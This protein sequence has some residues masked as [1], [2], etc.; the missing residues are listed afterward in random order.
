MSLPQ[1][2]MLLCLIQ[3]FGRG[4]VVDRVERAVIVVCMCARG[5]LETLSFNLNYL[6][7]GISD[8]TK[9]LGL[10]KANVSKAEIWECILNSAA[11][12]TFQDAFSRHSCINFGHIF[13]ETY[14]C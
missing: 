13:M 9:V 10:E 8:F 5:V 6:V 4:F 11:W 2:F 3:T 7:S 12:S 14:L 1:R